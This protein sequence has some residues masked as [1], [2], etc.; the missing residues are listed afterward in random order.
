LSALVD[1]HDAFWVNNNDTPVHFRNIPVNGATNSAGVTNVDLAFSYSVNTIDT[2]NLQ[3]PDSVIDLTSKLSMFN[4]GGDNLA[5]VKLFQGSSGSSDATFGYELKALISHFGPGLAITYSGGQVHITW[6]AGAGFNLYQ[7][8]TA[9]GSSGWTQ[10]A[11]GTAGSFN[12]APS[13]S[14]FYTLRAP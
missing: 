7:S 2:A 13:G 9:N 12:A 5:A 4:M 8:N 11:L 10:V 6:P 1:D 14:K 3:I